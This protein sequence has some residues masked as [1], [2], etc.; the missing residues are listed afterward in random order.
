MRTARVVC[1][2]LECKRKEMGAPG[3]ANRRRGVCGAIRLAAALALVL[4][5][6]RVAVSQ[7]PTGSITGT[8]KDAQGLSVADAAVTLTNLQTNASYTSKTGS[9][10]GYQFERIDYGLY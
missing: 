6:G 10:G 2:G 3:R 5:C 8:V 1:F 9:L 7:V 4:V